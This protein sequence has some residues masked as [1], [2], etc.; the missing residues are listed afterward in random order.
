MPRLSTEKVHKFALL[1][2]AD[3]PS[4]YD[5][6]MADPQSGNTDIAKFFA[7]DFLE[8]EPFRTADEQAELLV[9]RT[10]D[11]VSTHEETLSPQ[12]RG[13]VLQSVRTLL[14]DRATRAEPVAPRDLVAA[15]PLNEPRPQETVIQLQQS[16]ATTLTAPQDGV[17]S[18]PLNRELRIH[19]VP[20]LA[21]PARV[22]YELDFGVQLSGEPE[23][24]ERLFVQP[25]H[26]VADHTELTLRTLT[27]RPVG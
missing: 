17:D 4:T 9:T 7:D 11:W 22:T 2:C 27:F 18:I 24:I 10:F 1:R 15:L 20:R 21:R 26:R 16:F 12:E 14:A 6:L 8:T 19:T 23:A 5:V 25:P 13:A 3:D